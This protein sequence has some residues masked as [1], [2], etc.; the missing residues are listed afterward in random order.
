MEYIKD[1]TAKKTMIISWTGTNNYLKPKEVDVEDH[2]DRIETILNYYIDFFRDRP[3][4]LTDE[5]NNSML[6]FS[7]FPKLE[8]K[9][10]PSIGMIQSKHLKSS[11]R[12]EERGLG[13]EFH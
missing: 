6:L 9:I 5:Q 12:R 11:C 13:G 1:S 4:L 7:T 3:A 8:D 10:L 2:T